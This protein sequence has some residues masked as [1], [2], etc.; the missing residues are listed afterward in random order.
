MNSILCRKWNNLLMNK[1]SRQITGN[2]G[3][4]VYTNNWAPCVCNRAHN[5]AAYF[6]VFI[7]SS[8]VGVI[9]SAQKRSY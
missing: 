3:G 4:A 6:G 9:C 1:C 2:R 5:W 8:T 7:I